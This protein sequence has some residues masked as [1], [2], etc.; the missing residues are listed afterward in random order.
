M[1]YLYKIYK[2]TTLYSTVQIVYYA[3][4]LVKV[5]I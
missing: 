4:W 5:Y 1:L 2:L 3:L